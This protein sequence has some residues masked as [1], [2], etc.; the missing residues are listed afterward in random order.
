MARASEI[1][2]IAL[3]NSDK[4]KRFLITAM[5]AVRAEKWAYR[6]LIALVNAGLEISDEEAAAGMEGLAA[7]ASRGKFK[8]T[9]GGIQFHEIEP[10][11]DQMLECVQ[12]AEPAITRPLSEDDIDRPET[13]M[14]L[15]SEV[16]R[17]H[18]GF[19]LAERMSK[20]L[21]AFMSKGS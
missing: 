18:T 3:D 19:S 7:V 5:S 6:V 8:L 17:V 11:L 2:T 9:G 1:V 15:R 12:I 14:F 10:L 4:G 20:P 13:V 16:L 21:Q